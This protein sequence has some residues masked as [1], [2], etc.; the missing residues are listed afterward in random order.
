MV[1]GLAAPMRAFVIREEGNA[2]TIFANTAAA[3]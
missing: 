1:I 3:L 2:N